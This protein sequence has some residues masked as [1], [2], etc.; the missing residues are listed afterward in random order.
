MAHISVKAPE[1]GFDTDLLPQDAHEHAAVGRAL[2]A[3]EAAARVGTAPRLPSAGHENTPAGGEADQLAL[4][5]A[6]AAA[7]TAPQGR[8]SYDSSSGCST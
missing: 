4:R 2:E 6:S 7:G 1:L 3:R 8:G 5:R